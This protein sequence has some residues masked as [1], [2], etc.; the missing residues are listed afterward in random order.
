M[1][2]KWTKTQTLILNKD[3]EEISLNKL[4]KEYEIFETNTHSIFCDD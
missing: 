3:F 2:K 4:K 1:D